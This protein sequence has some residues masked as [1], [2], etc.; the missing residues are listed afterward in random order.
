MGAGSRRVFAAR[1]FP[2]PRCVVHE[3]S[4]TAHGACWAPA[5]CAARR[6]G[7]DGACSFGEGA[8]GGLFGE[9]AGTRAA[10]CRRPP[11]LPAFC[12]AF[13]WFTAP[14][15]C[16]GCL[17]PLVHRFSAVG[18]HTTHAVTHTHLATR[19]WGANARYRAILQVLLARVAVCLLGQ[20]F[21]HT[22]QDTVDVLANWLAVRNQVLQF[23]DQAPCCFTVQCCPSL[24]ERL[25]LVL[26]SKEEEEL[27]G[28]KED[29]EFLSLCPCIPCFKDI[30]M[31]QVEYI[32]NREREGKGN[33]LLPRA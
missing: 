19:L 30:L 17:H 18:K 5:S 7:L 3:A 31:Y 28:S 4:G 1:L 27:V 14:A 20:E 24:M 33:L 25:C 10:P 29:E 26:L 9:G 15:R 23:S 2:G 32:E 21:Q 12:A 8:H 6:R 16:T 22:T 11:K 13:F